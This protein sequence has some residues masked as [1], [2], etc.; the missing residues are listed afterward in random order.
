MTMA[1]KIVVMNK[2]FVQQIGRPMD[3]YENP[4]NLFVATFIG[5]PA[6]NII[7]AIYDK[8]T[9]KFNDG[10]EIKLGSNYQK[11]HDDFYKSK[12]HELEV[13]LAKFDELGKEE[14]EKIKSPK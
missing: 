6:M 3:I 7:D 9:I 11:V 12:I 10:F 8:E 1:D 13:I 14:I 5:S 2:G 4:E